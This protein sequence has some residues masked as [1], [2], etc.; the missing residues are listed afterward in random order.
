[1]FIK[2]ACESVVAFIVGT[3]C[4]VYGPRRITLDPSGFEE[5]LGIGRFAFTYVYLG[6]I[7]LVIAYAVKVTDNSRQTII[8][9]DSDLCIKGDVII[10][11]NT[12]DGPSGLSEFE[13][14][15]IRN[16][17]SMLTDDGGNF[18][19]LENITKKASKVS[20]MLIIDG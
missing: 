18:Y 1:M 9:L 7:P 10:L 19:R 8:S 14:N 17:L 6:L 20:S 4:N 2:Q 12:K 13:I 11:K 15:V 3:E 16:N 5:Y